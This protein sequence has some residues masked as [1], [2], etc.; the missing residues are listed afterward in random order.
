M[1]PAGDGVSFLEAAQQGMFAID[2]EAADQITASIAQIQETLTK[3]L[4]RIQD[5]KRQD[6]MLGDLHE[7]QAIATLDTLVATGAPQS[8]D[9]VLQRFSEELHNLNQAVQI[10]M[11]TYEQD[12]AQAAQSFRRI[13][14]G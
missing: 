14:E 3:Q 5:L 4:R 2:T 12:D 6:A 7:A 10:C 9:F 8:L 11:R 1:Q 13:G